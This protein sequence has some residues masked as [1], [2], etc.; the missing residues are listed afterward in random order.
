LEPIQPLL[1]KVM[2]CLEYDQFDC[3]KPKAPLAAV[4]LK[5]DSLPV[6]LSSGG[7]KGGR[8]RVGL[9]RDG[10]WLGLPTI[11]GRLE[12][13]ALEEGLLERYPVFLSVVL[14]HVSEATSVFWN[15]LRCLQL[16]LEILGY[17]LWL[18]TT[19][20]A[21]VVRNTLISQCFHSNQERM[22]NSIFEQ[23]QPFL[24]VDIWDYI[25]FLLIFLLLP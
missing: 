21:G 17:K 25:L 22:H 10:I 16:L 3:A 7:G 23:F 19:F 4:G 1:Q 15:A 6:L 5:Q 2:H 18:R 24:Q 9:T 14:N 13:P 11:L 12:A 8:Q 20:S